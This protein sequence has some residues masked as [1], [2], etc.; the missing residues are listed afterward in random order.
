MTSSESPASAAEQRRA[1]LRRSRLR[2]WGRGWSQD[3]TAYIHTCVFTFTPLEY[4]TDNG[5]P[6]SVLKARVLSH[7]SSYRTAT[8]KKPRL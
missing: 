6:V 2:G 5:I 3:H 1:V 8:E 7:P 4:H